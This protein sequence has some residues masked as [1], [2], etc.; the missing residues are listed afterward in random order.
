MGAVADLRKGLSDSINVLE[1]KLKQEMDTDQQNLEQKI[2]LIQNKNDVNLNKITA[3]ETS[4]PETTKTLLD[5]FEGQFKD[6]RNV[7][8]DKVN[9]IEGLLSK[10]TETIKFHASQIE[11]HSENINSFVSSNAVFSSQISAVETKSDDFIKY[12]E[13]ERQRID[14]IGSDIENFDEFIQNANKRMAE[15]NISLGSVNEK[16]LNNDQITE[17]INGVLEQH[18]DDIKLITSELESLRKS[19]SNADTTHLESV[20]KMKELTILISNIKEQII[21]Q[22]EKISEKST[23]DSNE[24]KSQIQVIQNEQDMSSKMIKELDNGSQ[25]ILEKLISLEKDITERCGDLDQNDNHLLSKLETMTSDF[26]KLYDSSKVSDQAVITQSEKIEQMHSYISEIENRVNTSDQKIDSNSTILLELNGV[27][28]NNKLKIDTLN[29]SIGSL[30]TVVEKFELQSQLSNQKLNELDSGNQTMLQRMKNQEKDFGDR[31]DEADELLL[32]KF[33]YLDSNNSQSLMQMKEDLKKKFTEI[34]EN[35]EEYLKKQLLLEKELQK[36]LLDKEKLSA[37]ILSINE[38]NTKTLSDIKVEVD[39][40]W[41]ELEKTLTNSIVTL[42]NEQTSVNNDFKEKLE[43]VDVSLDFT[44]KELRKLLETSNKYTQNIQT[45][46]ILNDKISNFEDN[47][48]INNTKLKVDFIEHIAK[49][50]D[51]MKHYVQL[52]LDELEKMRHKEHVSLS[53]DNYHLAKQIEEFKNKHRAI[54]DRVVDMNTDQQQISFNLSSIQ[55]HYESRFKSINENESSLM[56]KLKDIDEENK[57]NLEKIVAMEELAMLQSEKAQYIETLTSR[58]N[59]ID[60]MRQMSEVQAKEDFDKTVS[61]NARG[62]ED[63]KISLE[64]TMTKIESHLQEENITLK[65]EN[66]TINILVKR[67]QEDANKQNE[68]LIKFLKEKSNLEIKLEETIKESSILKQKGTELKNTLANYED[69]FDK[70]INQLQNEAQS[71]SKLLAEIEPQVKD[72]NKHLV[73]IDVKNKDMIQETKFVLSNET[74]NLID[75]MRKEIDSAF[76]VNVEKIAEFEQAVQNLKADNE[77]AF[78]EKQTQ[79]LSL[80][81]TTQTHS[82]NISE[83]GIK[84]QSYDV[85]QKA[86]VENLLITS[87]AQLNEIRNKYDGK[88]SEILARCDEY[89]EMM[90]T[91]ELKILSISDHSSKIEEDLFHSQRDIEQLKKKGGTD[92]E[93]IVMKIKEQKESLESFFRSLEQKMEIIETTQIKESSRVQVIERRTDSQDRSASHLEE[94]ILQVEKFGERQ[95][96]LILAVEKTTNERVEEIGS[97]LMDFVNN[98]REDLRNIRG[99]TV[100]IKS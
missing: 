70:K 17:E 43:S 46:E 32:S 52:N 49:T 89:N 39:G 93:L 76:V 54:E 60:E 97:E 51:E 2:L 5:N 7:T 96:S 8:D 47:I 1:V 26:N 37:E 95:N 50:T 35:S 84:L 58:V 94:K 59:Q 64:Q 11:I 33:N 87:E 13:V 98:S 91:N 45:L 80:I 34:E 79:I 53:N 38:S 16:L 36:F 74:K 3:L 14:N 23:N 68:Q 28:G 12:L 48:Q 40:T 83:I 86:I 92:K 29:T 69:V 19:M 67:L 18:Q 62:I 31:F 65:E 81:S 61:K 24:M 88:F 20:E 71:S 55:E 56:S 15:I 85:K 82:S 30:H 90:E 21:M 77:E 4:G 41:K 73:E 10:N 66:T 78:R 72:F 100:V 63:L 22:E 6:L 75:L 42:E 44:Y 57:R 27:L 9:E 25:S 99:Y